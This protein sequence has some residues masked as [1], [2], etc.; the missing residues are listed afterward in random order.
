MGVLCRVV[1]RDQKPGEELAKAAGVTKSAR[2][3]HVL[4]E[5]GTGGLGLLQTERP[6][7]REPRDASR[8]GHSEES[9]QDAGFTPMI[10]GICFVF[11]QSRQ[12]LQFSGPPHPWAMMLVRT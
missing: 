12:V 10:D 2:S 7:Q 1:Q 6:C 9:A 4:S 11:S 5:L 8:G 3:Q